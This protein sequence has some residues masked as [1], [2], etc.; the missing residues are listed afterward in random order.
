MTFGISD[1]VWEYILELESETTEPF[2]MQTW[3]V[4]YFSDTLQN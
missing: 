3:L 1:I 4:F 2:D